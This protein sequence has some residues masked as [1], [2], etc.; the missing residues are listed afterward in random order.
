MDPRPASHDPASRRPQPR[1]R[2]PL[3]RRSLG[4]LAAVAVVGLALPGPSAAG[5]P[6]PARTRGGAHRRRLL[7]E[8]RRH[9]RRRAA[10]HQGRGRGGELQLPAGGV[11]VPGPPRQRT[12]VVLLHGFVGDSTTW[13]TPATWTSSLAGSRLCWST[14]GALP[15]AGSRRAATGAGRDPQ[16]GRQTVMDRDHRF[17]PVRPPTWRLSQDFTTLNSRNLQPE[18]PRA[19]LA[20]KQSGFDQLAGERVPVG[21]HA[22][23]PRLGR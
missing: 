4:L 13:G 16:R 11:G 22:S 21:E 1:R 15:A 20:R 2:W 7:P 6:A 5:H 12:P 19:D 23:W 9:L 18:H 3:P 17:R 8:L 10:G 14:P